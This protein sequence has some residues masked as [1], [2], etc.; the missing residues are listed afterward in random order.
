MK[1]SEIMGQ[2]QTNS[3]KNDNKTL[4]KDD[5]LKLLVTQ[6][7]FQ[8]PLKPMEDKE[9]IAQMAQ[10]SSLEQMQNLNSSFKQFAESAELMLANQQSSLHEKLVSQAIGLIGKKVT[11]ITESGEVTGL[12]NKIRM[13]DG[14]PKLLV[15]DQLIS[16]SLVERIELNNPEAEAATNS[17]EN[18]EDQERV[19]SSE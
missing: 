6:L 17:E 5:F 1:V 11:A 10:F 3:T 14:I 8:D 12:V 7:K 13:V 18:E 16:L 2:S 15:N 4:G 19:E 9:F